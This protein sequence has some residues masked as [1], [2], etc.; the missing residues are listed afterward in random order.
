MQV[1]PL[2][3]SHNAK[4]EC[5]TCFNGYS[6]IN[7][8][9]IPTPQA[10][11]PYCSLFNGTK[12]LQCSF[13]YRFNASGLCVAQDYLCKL[14]HPI[15]YE[16]LLCYP[17]FMVGSEGKCGLIT[18]PGCLSWFNLSCEAC[19]NGYYLSQGHCHQID[20]LC[21]RFNYTSLKCS[22]CYFGYVLIQ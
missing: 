14:Y 13:G 18:E 4:G 20:P 22:A 11:D 3:K 21:S 1:N 2:C 7:A 10:M 8:S 12:C 6:V 15:T 5:L 9:C 19:S 17:G 16:C